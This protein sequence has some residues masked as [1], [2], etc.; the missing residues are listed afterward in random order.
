MVKRLR[1]EGYPCT[2]S[3]AHDPEGAV[4][5]I[6][7]ELLGGDLGM[8]ADLPDSGTVS[9]SEA[10]WEEYLPPRCRKPRRREV[11]T[12]ITTWTLGQFRQCATNT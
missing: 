4:D 7:R 8:V 10:T 5:D 12:P 11:V 3:R 9:L 1:I 6:A 2:I